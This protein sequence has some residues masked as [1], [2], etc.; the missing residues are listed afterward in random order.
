MKIEGETPPGTI[1]LIKMGAFYRAYNHSAW[2]FQ[3]CITEHKVIRKYVKALKQNIWFIGFPGE[4]LFDTIGER[5]AEKTDY[6]FDIKLG[7]DEV[8]SDEAYETWKQTVETV[9]SSKADYYALPLA[10]AEAEKEVLRRL[11]AYPL[12]SK[13][14]VEAVVF[15]SELRQ[16]LNNK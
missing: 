1:R 2:L 6:G 3:A 12:E 9:D 4:R 10:G 8:P 14:M 15:L 5:T 16:L 13:S 7:A 11:R